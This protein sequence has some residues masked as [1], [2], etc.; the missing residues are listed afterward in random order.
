MQ[1]N[2]VKKCTAKIK[3]QKVIT[4]KVP[5]NDKHF[6]VQLNDHLTYKKVSVIFNIKKKKNSFMTFR[7][8]TY[9][10]CFFSG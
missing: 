5:E 10:N 7:S 2:N 6:D 3:R 8:V 4:N 1:G 9:N